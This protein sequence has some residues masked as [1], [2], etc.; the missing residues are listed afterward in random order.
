MDTLLDRGDG[1]GLPLPAALAER[2]GGPLRVPPRFVYANFVSTLDGVVS[3]DAPGSE[4]ASAVSQGHAG[5]RFVLALL[6]AFADAV[7]VGAGTLRT[8]AT[9]VWTPEHVFPE[10]GD[11]FAELRRTMHLRPHPL[12]VIVSASGYVARGL[13]ALPSGVPTIIVTGTRRPREI[14]DIARA[15]S[16][17][18][19][20]LTEGGPTLLGRFLE[21]GAV[22]ELFLTIAP[23]LAGRSDLLRRLALVEGTAFDPATA[24]RGRVISVKAEDDYLFTRFALT[25]RVALA[26][27]R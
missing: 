27:G 26:Q 16:G 20:T 9:S 8:E 3:F 19:R 13:P 21:D 5:D 12:T 10:A 1:D 24:P 25:T 4:S 18:E 17:G 6:R 22:D 7:I 23:R 14:V 15:E 2:Y 11:A